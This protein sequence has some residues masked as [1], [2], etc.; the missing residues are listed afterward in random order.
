[1]SFDPVALGRLGGPNR[2]PGTPATLRFLLRIGLAAA[3]AAALVD[4]VLLTG[5]RAAGWDTTVD[6]TTVQPVGVVGVCLVVGVI[7]AFGAYVAARVTVRPALWVLLAGA[8]ICA[9]SLPGLPPAILALHVVTAL[10]VVGLLARAVRGGS[11][12]RH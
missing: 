5:A 7:G 1:M 9:A 4:L 10:L 3:V 6:G 8:G 11:H 2:R 12:L